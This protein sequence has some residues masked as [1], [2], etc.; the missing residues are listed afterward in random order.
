LALI[1]LTDKVG[2]NVKVQIF[3]HVRQKIGTFAEVTISHD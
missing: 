2:H 3:D 1:R